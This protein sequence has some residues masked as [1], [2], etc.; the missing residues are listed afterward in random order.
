MVRWGNNQLYVNQGD[1]T[2]VESAKQYGLDV[3]SHSTS[4]VFADFD[5][6]GDPDL[7]L[8]RYEARSIYFENQNG[9]FVD[10]SQEKVKTPLPGMV[11][12]VSAADYNGDGLLDVYFSTYGNKLAQLNHFLPAEKVKEI[13][14]FYKDHDTH[15]EV[16]HSAGA[17]NQL[18]INLGGTFDLAPES[19]Q[20]EFFQTSFQST[21][22]DYDQDGDPDLYVCNDFGPDY[23]MRNDFPNGFKDVTAEIGDESMRGFGMG[24]T[25]GD[26]DLDGR[27]DMY[28][29]A[30]YSK[31]GMRITSQLPEVDE[32]FRRS[33]DGNRLYRQGDNGFEYVSGL[34]APKLL[35][36][37]VGWSWGGQFVDFDNDGFLD[38][39]VS[40]GYFP[41]PDEVAIADD[42]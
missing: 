10:Q 1:G 19:K 26:Y 8:G 13:N 7:F 33:A 25:W 23:L 2:F 16:L 32:G 36:A 15:H 34:K 12:S 6:D 38:L 14:D 3:N 4:A 39:Y 37:K 31:A 9:K 30:M 24:V 17:P 22:A 35:V 18:L 21:W 28:V 5:N 42:L 20:L 11:V 40:S 27:Q 41:A 29:S